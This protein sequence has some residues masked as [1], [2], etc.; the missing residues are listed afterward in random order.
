MLARLSLLS[1]LCLLTACA[2]ALPGYSPPPYK[3]EKSALLKPMESG[4]LRADGRYVMSETEKTMDCKR[5]TGSMLITISRL[6]DARNRA[7]G[8]DL[9]M[10]TQKAVKQLSGGSSVG[11][12]PEGD[13]ARERAKLE[14]YNNELAARNCAKLDIE[15]EMER[16]PEGPIKY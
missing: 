13:H 5:M 3:E 16:P 8:S 4:T 9:A 2:A 11:A 7:V 15:A 12:D 1:S 10:S 6:K 14:A